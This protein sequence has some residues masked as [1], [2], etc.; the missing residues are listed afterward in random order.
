MLIFKAANFPLSNALEMHPRNFDMLCFDFHSR[1]FLSSFMIFFFNLPIIW[2]CA[3]EFP[4]TL[5]F[6]TFSY[7]G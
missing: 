5:R 4:N 2:K 3:T 1:C 7:C 6:P